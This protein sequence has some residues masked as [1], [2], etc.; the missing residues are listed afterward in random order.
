[1]AEAATRVRYSYAEYVSFERG[2]NVK[3]EY[4]QGEILAM[5]GGT[6]EHAQLA[7]AVIR[8]LGG[9]LRGSTCRVFTSDLRVRVV[10]SGPRDHVAVRLPPMGTRERLRV[11]SRMLANALVETAWRNGPVESSALAYDAGASAVDRRAWRRTSSAAPSSGAA[12]RR[13][14][15]WLLPRLF[16]RRPD[17]FLGNTVPAEVPDEPLDVWPARGMR[18]AP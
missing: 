7:A 15:G 16:H 17:D 4:H 11:H 18:A 5:A 9:Q 14:G 1:M 13:R 8:D 10:A 2:S 6:A 12:P 3:H